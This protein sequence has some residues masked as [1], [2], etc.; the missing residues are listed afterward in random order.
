M[1]GRRGFCT[2]AT[3]A[4]LIVAVQAALSGHD[5]PPTMSTWCP[6]G[7]KAVWDMGKAYRETTPTSERICDQ[8]AVA[9]ATG[10]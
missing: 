5:A 7:V 6:A 9:L 2:A 4:F 10:R 8:R 3:A 1:R